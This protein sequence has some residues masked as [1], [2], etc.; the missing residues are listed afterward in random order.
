M[1]CFPFALCTFVILETFTERERERDKL[2][3]ELHWLP[4]NTAQNLMF[5]LLI[6]RYIK[7][8]P[9]LQIVYIVVTVT[10]HV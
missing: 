3:K 1:L 6:T 10:A 2:L 8:I 9:E 5:D 4:N 7:S